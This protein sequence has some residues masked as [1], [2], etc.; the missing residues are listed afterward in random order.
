M[1]AFTT[2]GLRKRLREADPS[3]AAARAAESLDFLEFS[4][5]DGSV[6]SDVKFLQEHPLIL[7]D[8]VITGW[9]YHVESGKVSSV[10]SSIEISSL[11]RCI[12]QTGGVILSFDLGAKKCLTLLDANKILKC[13]WQVA[14][15]HLLTK[16][17]ME[18]VPHNDATER[19]QLLSST[20]PKRTKNN[21]W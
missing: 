9:V 17:N 3:V 1:L 20:G 6:K 14:R 16:A 21:A 10:H 18:Y 7:K 2:A 12:D 8:T 15:N 19:I 11:T 13:H 4:D 5:L